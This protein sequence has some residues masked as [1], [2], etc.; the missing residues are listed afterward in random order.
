MDVQKISGLS[1][2]SANPTLRPASRDAAESDAR[3]ETFQ[4]RVS[5]IET[6]LS[7]YFPPQLK[8]QLDVDKSTGTV[9]GRVVDKKT[10][11]FVRQVPS[12]EMIAL[13]QRSA[14]I[15]ALLDK[16]V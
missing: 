1:T 15:T 11:E 14:E 12:E 10:G 7:A 16:T 9:V 3:A 13:M 5:Q 6:A 2:A 8:L 4:A